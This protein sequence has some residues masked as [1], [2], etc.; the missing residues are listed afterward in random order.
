MT[1]RVIQ[2]PNEAVTDDGQYSDLLM[3][4]GQY[5]GHDIAFTPQSTSR[6][7]LGGAADC[8]LTCEKQSPCFPIQVEFL[9]FY[10]LL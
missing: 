6:A 1:R 3:V 4:W 5:I 10:F 9:N 7:A 2:A 8:Q